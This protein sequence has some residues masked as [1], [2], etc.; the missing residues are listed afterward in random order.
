V[1][2]AAYEVRRVP[3]EDVPQVAELMREAF[4]STTDDAW[5][6]S[7]ERSHSFGAYDGD[8]LVSHARVKP[9]RQWFG[10]RAVPMGGV[11]SVAVTATHQARGLARRTTAALLPFLREQGLVVSALYPATTSLY[12]SLGWEHAG[13]YTWVEVPAASLRALGPPGEVT[14]RPATE[15]DLPAVFAAYERHCRETNGMLAREGPF[16]DLRPETVLGGTAVVAERDGIEGY[17]LAT[18]AST[19]HGVAVRA[20][21]VVAT[22][23]EAE[24][25]LWF[26]L[27]AG[28]SWAPRVEAKVFAD[29][30]ALHLAEPEYTVTDHRRWM[31]RVIDAPGAVAARGWPGGVEASVDL[32][33]RDDLVP[34]NAG[35]WRLSVAAGAA[36]LERGGDGTVALDAGAFAALYAS[37]GD[38]RAL[39]RAGRL[40]CDDDRALDLLAAVTAGPRPRLLDYF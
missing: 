12:R 20:N 14:L 17:A 36:T 25:A 6:H 11:A 30:L 34:E 39:R 29:T 8:R 28:A 9:Y 3:R 37:Y 10:G 4:G 32:D 26:A 19:G 27:G 7:M 13:D 16:F 18:R 33:L 15:G 23:A 22:T 31:L 2:G 38:P 1:T 35:R 24:R 5:H 21:D 40:R